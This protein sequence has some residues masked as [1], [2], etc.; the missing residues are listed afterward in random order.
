MVS[1]ARLSE[2]GC[3]SRSFE[4]VAFLQWMEG[5]PREEERYKQGCSEVCGLQ[6]KIGS[7]SH[8]GLINGSEKHG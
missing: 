3:M 2:G 5:R 1:G 8:P 7:A 6:P 4:G